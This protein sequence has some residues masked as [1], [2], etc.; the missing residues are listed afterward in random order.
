M[1]HQLNGQNDDDRMDK[2][3]DS[4]D[5]GECKSHTLS[6]NYLQVTLNGK[7]VKAKVDTGADLNFISGK[8]VDELPIHLKNRFKPIQRKVLCAN[9]STATTRGLITLPIHIHNQKFSVNFTV[10]DHTSEEMFLGIPFFK[11]HKAKIDFYTNKITLCTSNPVHAISHCTLEPFSEAIIQGKLFRTT[12]NSTPGL[13]TVFPAINT[14]GILIANTAVIAQEDMVPIRIFNG[15]AQKQK[16]NRGERLATFDV[17]D[18]TVEAFYY[19]PESDQDIPQCSSAKMKNDKQKSD[20]YVPDID[21]S[22]TEVN[23]EQMD[24]LKQLINE[25][26][27]CFVNPKTNKLGLTDLISCSI[28][29]Y[30]DSKPVHK[31]PY[32]MAPSQKEEMQKMVNQQMNQGLIEETQEGAWASPALLVKKPNGSFRM[33]IDYRALNAA[34]IPKILRAPRL[35]D[36]L[37]SVGETKPKFF[38]VLDCTQGFHQIPLDPSSRNKTAF[39]TPH[40]KYRYKTMPQGLKTASATF[41]ALMDILLRG[42]QFKYVC[43]YI[44]DVICYS[45]TFEQHLGHLREVLGRFRKANLKLHPRKCHFA[46][47]KV[48]FLGHVLSP[49]GIKPNPDKV[50]V[51]KSYPKP[52]N[53]KQV[54][55]FLGLTGFYR[56]YI[57]HYA[58]IAQPLYNLTK[59]DVTFKWSDECQEAFDK[60]K[61]HITSESILAFP[62]F[63][64][65]FVLATDA[66]KLGIGACL[67][68]VQDGEMK[69]IAFTGRG[70]SKA[71]GN[72]NVTEQELL[73]IVYAVQKFKVYLLG[74]KFKIDTD[75]KALKWLLSQNDTEGRIARWVNILQQYQFE[76]CHIKGKDN[77]VPD[78]LSRRPYDTLR[79]E[80]DEVIDQF[81]DLD[82]IGAAMIK[83]TAADKKAKSKRKVSKSKRSKKSKK[84]KKEEIPVLP[85]PTKSGKYKESEEE[86]DESIESMDKINSITHKANKR[87]EKLRP[88]LQ[89]TGNENWKEYDFSK[90]NI[91]KEQARDEHCSKWIEFLQAG[92]LPEDQDQARKILVRQEEYIILEGILYHIHTSPGPKIRDATAQLVI[93]QNLK[94]NLLELHHD[95]ALGGHTGAKRMISL[96]RT[97]Y[98]WPGVTEDIEQYVR[99]CDKCIRAKPMSRKNTPEMQIREPVPAF[100][101]TV[102][103]DC[104]GPFPRSKNGNV[105]LTVVTDQMSRYTIAWPSR[106]IKGKT[107]AKKFWEKVVCIYGCPRRILSDNGA[108]FVSE[109]FQN[110]CRMYNIKNVYSPSYYP[111]A[112]GETERMNRTI[113]GQLRTLVSKKQT[114]WD[115]HIP[116]LVFSINT[117][118]NRL[119]GEMAYV[120]VF[121]K[122]PVFPAEVQLPEVLTNDKPAHEHLVDI[123]Q[124]QAM[125]SEMAKEKL[126]EE[127][128]AL[129]EYYDKK[130]TE[131][132]IM[133]G[134][135][136]Y[137]YHPTITVRKTKKKLVSPYVGPYM[138]AGYKS[139]NN[140]NLRRVS[141][142]KFLP[143][144]IHI[145]RL[146]VG[147]VREDT[148]RWDPLPPGEGED[149]AEDDIPDGCFEDPQVAPSENDSD[150]DSTPNRQGLRSKKKKTNKNKRS[151]DKEK[152]NK[153]NDTEK[154]RQKENDI[155]DV[156]DEVDKN[157]M[158]SDIVAGALLPNGK[159]R[160]IVRI[161]NIRGSRANSDIK[162]QCNMTDGTT[163]WITKARANPALIKLAERWEY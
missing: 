49:E 61:N 55:G 69:P 85:E 1:K 139:K 3:Q 138:V 131:N 92:R 12:E 9:Q 39:L 20:D 114:D 115:E 74:Q 123:V 143:K 32:R 107:I 151:E 144:A 30:S 103:I 108:C 57:K 83:E 7:T 45:N 127:S 31:Y 100:L 48:T 71:E 50:E 87:R 154:P 24:Q 5:K 15:T 80:V 22:K 62:D 19:N 38:S 56:K 153:N 120:L 73:A 160:T 91:M 93:P 2:D 148:S 159:F 110:L 47:K 26:S 135:Y 29:T 81:P 137:V 140:V 17:W 60:L 72:Y 37:D 126:A 145:S 102:I 10:F 149:I 105:Y 136:V 118:V 63:N 106:D 23:G 46:V 111:K 125:V 94:R 78:A 128:K 43:A 112:Q 4:D 51:I 66:S 65:P 11:Q 82:A 86:D 14:K 124:T 59:K 28:D 79:T 113:L 67:S 53:L 132:K 157:L 161:L 146:K 84:S 18:D 8:V 58:I 97:K 25:Y 95:T 152:V 96:F 68:Q 90:E 42:I 34:T 36:V 162:Y 122:H 147:K 52:K 99:S 88:Q 104:L 129:K 35:D 21:W 133:V 64:K 142:G 130:A 119:R 89:R 13:C 109:F 117:T 44:D 116:A 40:G 98:Y 76:V 150:S 54:R 41:Q 6:H 27:D 77:A 16:I 141:D 101:D 163:Q 75:H 121:G 156:S 33:V 158:K 70:L 155:V 134:N